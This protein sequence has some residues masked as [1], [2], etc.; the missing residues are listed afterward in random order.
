MD[1]K[2]YVAYRFS[3]SGV[4]RGSHPR[5]EVTHPPPWLTNRTMHC[6]H[7]HHGLCMLQG[8]RFALM[9]GLHSDVSDRTPCPGGYD[10]PKSAA[11]GRAFARPR[12]ARLLTKAQA[13]YQCRWLWG[14]RMR[15]SL[16][17]SSRMVRVERRNLVLTS[18]L[19]RRGAGHRGRASVRYR[20]PDGVLA[21]W[22]SCVLRLDYWGESYVAIAF[23]LWDRLEEEC[24][25]AAAE[26]CFS[27]MPAH[28]RASLL[29]EESQ[30]TMWAHYHVG[31]LERKD[32]GP[33]SVPGTRGG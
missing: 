25:Y 23:P 15:G 29:Y 10:S 4:A 17:S 16:L 12:I 28:T 22:S 26:H 32:F 14:Q 13:S 3:T 7:Y 9:K 27:L 18:T 21:S 11:L 30:T 8:C 33:R 20:A 24:E 2:G 19:P 1:K 5:W 31:A 6:W